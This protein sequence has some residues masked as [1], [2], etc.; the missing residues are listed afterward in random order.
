[1][2]YSFLL[3]MCIFIWIGFV[4]AISFMESWLKFRAPGVTLPL[5]LNIGKLVFSALNKVEWFFTI[6]TGVLLFFMLDFSTTSLQ[7]Y[8]GLAAAILILQTCWL[9]PTLNKR[10]VARI[11]GE[12]VAKSYLHFYFVI[13][14]FIK[15]LLL[16]F[17]AYGIF[18]LEG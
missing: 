15:I 8:F 1:M 10:A 3:L 12:T 16:F 17:L 14:E 11:K 2:F 9:L 6:A 4:G 7:L 18:N 5:G 13:A